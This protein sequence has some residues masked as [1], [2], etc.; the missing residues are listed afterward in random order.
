MLSTSKPANQTAYAS[1]FLR[2]QR[3]VLSK[4]K[5][6]QLVICIMFIVALYF[7]T[8]LQGQ[9]VQELKLIATFS[10][11]LCMG[12]LLVVNGVYA[13][14]AL[15]NSLLI[16]L[17][18]TFATLLSPLEGLALGAIITFLSLS[19]LLLLNLRPVSDSG[20]LHKVFLLANLVNLALAIGMVAD[21]SLVDQFIMSWYSDFYPE[22]LNNMIVWYNKPVLTF[23]SHSIAGLFMFLFMYAN[24]CTYIATRK[25][26][27][28]IFAISYLAMLWFLQSVTSLIL[29]ALGA[30][31]FIYRLAP[32]FRRSS[33]LLWIIGI[34]FVMVLTGCILILHA[35][36]FI[37]SFR[38]SY[39]SIVGIF[40]SPL[41]G[42][43]AR[44]STDGNLVNNIRFILQ[45]WY[46]PAGLGYSDKLFFGDSGQ[47]EYMVRGSF[48][49][50]FSIYGGLY[51]FLR[52]NL[53]SR[54]QAIFLFLTIFVA[55]IG[56][57]HL[58]Y[59]RLIGLLPFLIVYLNNLHTVPARRRHQS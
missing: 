24:V 26:I 2:R 57:T 22:L 29:L 32:T 5:L 11:W 51:F 35:E 10:L 9:I 30:T 39:T 1:S 13:K 15:S 21:Q 6:A 59:F 56:F 33:F 12:L 16:I 37:E 55:E 3:Q 58:K 53:R 36:L 42:F 54:R 20:F 44:F 19:L 4:V 50:L 14:L 28:W 38:Y 18:L 25:P 52:H 17:S 31:Y 34:L 8:S 46:R 49:L 7:P 45:S 40:T 43:L 41:G 47:I 27:Y 23:G 48:I